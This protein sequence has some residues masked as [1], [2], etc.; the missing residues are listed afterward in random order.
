MSA[1]LAA[2]LAALGLISGAGN[3]AVNVW[4]AQENRNFNAE[5]ARIAREFEERMSNTAV[6]RRMNDLRKAGINPILAYQ[7][8]GASTPS[9]S[10]AS[11]SATN[12]GGLPIT[13]P[14]FNQP[15]IDYQSN[16]NSAYKA[17]RFFERDLKEY[18]DKEALQAYK[19][20]KMA[21]NHAG[22]S[23]QNYILKMRK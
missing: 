7:Q 13:F 22:S 18:G 8:G 2:G 3:T 17:M 11:A 21:F 12:V 9:V 1:T 5:Q 20:A 10:P 15:G 4:Q 16:V 23:Y 6:Q 14:T 19:L